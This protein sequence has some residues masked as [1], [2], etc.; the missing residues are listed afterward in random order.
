VPRARD[1]PTCLGHPRRSCRRMTAG[2]AAPH[3][4]WPGPWEGA[5]TSLAAFCGLILGGEHIAVPT[6]VHH[7]ADK[8]P[9][10]GTVGQVFGAAHGLPYLPRREPMWMLAEQG[11]NDAPAVLHIGACTRAV[12]RRDRRRTLLRALHRH[13]P[14][15]H[16]RGALSV[17]VCRRVSC[18][19]A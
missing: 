18:P 19:L 1:A 10:E 12:G 4:D 14:G 15:G 5:P 11:H 9:R 2:L 13:D 8:E 17:L 16:A 7:T 6:L 3:S